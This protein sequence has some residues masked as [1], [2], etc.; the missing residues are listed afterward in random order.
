ML[1]RVLLL[2]AASIWGWTFVATKIL[3][4]ELGPV[5]V[6][7][8]RLAIGV[9][10]L[11]LVL[12]VRR[13][14]WRFE[15]ADVRPLVLAAAVLTVH[16]LVQ[17]VGLMSTTATNTSWIIS[18]SPLAVAVLSFLVLG[19]RIGRGGVAGI[20]IATVGIL[21]LVSRGRLGDLGWLRSTGDWLALASAHT[22]AL[23]TV[24]TRDLVRRREP[25][26][27]AFGILLI[28]G[29]F[30]G[31]LFAVSADLASVRALSP[32]GL[33]ALLYL[34][35]PGLALGQW[36]WQEGVARLGA[37]RA[38]LFLYLEPIATVLLAVP[39]L[40]ESF[41]LFMA[42]GGGLVLAGVY[43][44]QERQPA[45]SRDAEEDV[46]YT[47]DLQSP[48]GATAWADTAEQKRPAR[49][50]IRRAIGERL[51]TLAPGS[52]VLELGSGPGLLAEHVLSRCPQLA[53]Y[54][55]FDF[56]E[57][58]LEMSRARVGRFAAARF[59]LGDF[60]QD[61]WTRHV[62]GPYDAVVSMQAVHEV[63]HTR[64]VPRL[65]EQIRAMLAPGGLFLV[66]D[67]TPEDDTPRSR[68]LFMTA[69]E[70]A[71]ALQQ[72]GFVDVQLVMAADALAF[73]TCRKPSVG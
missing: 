39:L 11:G 46:P 45:R 44:G 8:L 53:S 50:P 34:A 55:L 61:D 49:G 35:I 23:Y 54:T 26:A 64:H 1:P 25:L 7:A 40:G 73:C 4:E 20:A 31:A 72:A 48:D 6:F 36:F 42:L 13:V 5:E 14:P 28:A 58:M 66:C 69:E 16:F 2:V 19:E 65:Y 38:G 60:R 37:T 12:L 47:E 3:L 15:R 18:V 68:A 29:V 59:V 9:P 57:P 41:G 62:S 67:R 21:L 33:A 56:S 52:R 63:R 27:V 70:Q 17:I 30:T 51:E 71:E 24:M 43:V 10:F 22:W 32:R